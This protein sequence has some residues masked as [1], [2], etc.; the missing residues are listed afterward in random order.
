MKISLT[1]K[2][3]LI[4]ISVFTLN[5]FAETASVIIKGKIVD[6][7]DKPV[8]Y[9]NAVLINP[10]NGEILR[11]EMSD[12]K[13]EFSIRKIDKGEY[14]LAVSMLGYN[15]FESEKLVVDA[16]R[17][18]IER[19][20]ILSERT[21]TLGD[22]VVT[23]K[24]EFIEQ[25]VDKIVINP[26]ASITSESENVFEILSK[27]PGVNVDNNDNITLKGLKG[28]K[29]LID[30]KPTYLSA[31]QLATMLKS[32]QGKQVER[33]EIIENPSARYDAEGNSG[34]IN[35]KTK[36]QKAPG[37]NGNVNAGI[38]V[39]SKLRSN[40][41][42]DL[43]MNSGKFNFYGNFSNNNWAG[44][45]GMEGLRRFTSP[46]L[47]GARQEIM[48]TAHYRGSGFNYKTGLDYYLAKNHVISAMFRGNHGNNGNTD[49]SSTA[50]YNTAQMLDSVLKSDAESKNSWKN[51]TYNLNYKWDIDTLGQSLQFDI[52]YARFRFN[53]DNSQEG[54]Y[55]DADDVDLNHDLI[56]NTNQGN[57]INIVTSKLDYV[58]PIGK[59]YHFESGLKASFVNTDSKIDM[60]GFMTQSDHFVYEEMIQAAYVNGRANWGK[61]TM[62]VGLR[63]E[64][65]ISKGTSLASMSVTDTTYLKFFPSFFVQQQLNEKHSVNFKYSYRIGRPGY[66]SLN[67]FKWMIDPFTYNVGN[68]YLKPQFTHTSG[69]THNWQ[70]FLIS[71]LNFNYTSGLFTEIIR[72]DDASRS[73]Y[74]TMENLNN[75]IDLSLSETL[76]MQ[77]L[78]WWRFNG[79]VTGMYK[80]I[81][82]S[83][84]NSEPLTQLSVM[85]NMNNYITLPLGINMEVNGR[86][87]SRQLVSNIIVN[88]RFTLDLGFQKRVLDNHGN[89]RLSVSDIFN[90][91]QNSAYAKYDNVDIEVKNRYD[92]RRLNLTFSYRFGKDDFKTRANRATSS[93][94]EQN[95]SQK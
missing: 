39:A 15:R 64:N 34:I 58:L 59:K 89:I 84:Q 6:E 8:E 81:L 52:D 1:K 21:E 24:R 25:A 27:L 54:K 36:H 79:T 17:S 20:I 30:D 80:S 68:P 29:V 72:Q 19:N 18:V 5:S 91:G 38:G 51:Q 23:A 85:A 13:G 7:N 28:V 73:V 62:Q 43:N 92:S 10:A 2:I 35:I 12:S 71:S 90:T 78:K 14:V 40:A 74:Q 46:A 22:V 93:S 32:M 82:L 94:E 77:P 60:T 37:F 49:V 70:N 95:R 83:D 63:L 75:S 66:H 16:R 55:Y 53:N 69:L 57:D 61:T 47:I 87:S 41:G 26:S 50:F 86:Y 88:P 67:P 48:T 11:G 56:V 76:Q 45:N 31:A 42:V 65:T 3:V 9:A 44:I 33:I 4:F